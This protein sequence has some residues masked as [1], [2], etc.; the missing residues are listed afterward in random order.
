MFDE[1][2]KYKNQ[3]HFFFSAEQELSK[4]CNAPKDRSGVYI[5]YELKKGR[6]ELVYIGC[7]GKVQ[8]DGS[9]KHRSSGGGGLYGRIV[10]GKQFGNIRKKSWKQK[11]IVEKIEAIDV[12]W[13]DTFNSPLKHIPAFVEATIIQLYYKQNKCL[14]RWNVKF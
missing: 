8:N 10:N 3:D 2:K 1:L 7:S 6:V 12:Y 4:V 13:Y 9:I 5:V 11:L 14:P